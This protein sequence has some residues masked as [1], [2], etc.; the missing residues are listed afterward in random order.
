MLKKLLL[1]VV[2]VVGVFAI[3]VALQPPEVRIARQATIAAP[4]A[5]VFPHV[6]ELKQ[7]NAWSPWAKLDPNAKVAFEGPAAGDGAAFSWSGNDDI[8]EGK[9]T[10]VESRR[11]D[12]VKL[13]L[14]F[15]KPFAGTSVSEFTF[16]PEGDK[17]LVTW[18]M[19]SQQSFLIRAMCILFNGNK[20]VGDQF[21]QGLANLKAVSEGKPG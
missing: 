10:I 18:E 11:S 16:K 1:A 12:L 21:E 3:Y 7:W 17:T 4:P 13:R 8:G 14:D 19:Q 9:M 15:V 2:A 20:M 6:N 5:A